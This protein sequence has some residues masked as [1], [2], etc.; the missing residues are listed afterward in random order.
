M[1]TEIASL[2]LALPVEGERGEIVSCI[3]TTVPAYKPHLKV[4]ILETFSALDQ[5]ILVSRFSLA[6]SPSYGQGCA[7]PS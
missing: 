2:M 3:R 1:K 7:H 4:S 6:K 5:T